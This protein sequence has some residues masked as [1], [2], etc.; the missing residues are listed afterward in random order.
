MPQSTTTT[1]PRF[2]IARRYDVAPDLMFRVWTEPRHLKHWFGPAGC[3]MPQ[4]RM[5]LR[6]GGRCLFQ[7]I[8]PDGSELWGKFVYREVVQNKRLVWM[9][10]FADAQGNTARHP[11]TDTWPLEILST[12]TFEP[13][14]GGTLITIDWR[15]IDPTEDE[16]KAFE[17]GMDSMRQGWGGSLEILH[18]YLDELIL[19][20]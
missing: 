9:H 12:V 18:D 17:S 6:P 7:L 13:D 4:C 20:A 15:P 14:T 2:T 11:M 1:E 19:S 3:E 10:S 8:M 16:Q 5:D